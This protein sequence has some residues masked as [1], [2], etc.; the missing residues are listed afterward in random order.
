ML[1]IVGQTYLLSGGR[2]L[3][4]DELTQMLEKSRNTVRAYLVELEQQKLV[5]RTSSRPL[6]IRLSEAGKTLLFPEH[7]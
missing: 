2:G 1:F 6:R 5:E 7:A 4:W 3:S